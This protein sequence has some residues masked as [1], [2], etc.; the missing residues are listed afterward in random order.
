MQRVRTCCINPDSSPI[1]VAITVAIAIAF[2]VFM[3]VI[4]RVG[5]AI[6]E[7]L[8]HAI[9]SISDARI[10][11][12]IEAELDVF[13]TCAD[14]HLVL[15]FKTHARP[16]LAVSDAEI[17]LELDLEGVFLD[18]EQTWEICKQNPAPFGAAKELP[19]RAYQ[20]W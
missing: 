12:F 11:A 19:L 17:D 7:L 15:L 16:F 1:I 8:H 20:H 18:A 5:V 10:F 13:S 9:P 4:V 14:D 2:S 3:S 6:E